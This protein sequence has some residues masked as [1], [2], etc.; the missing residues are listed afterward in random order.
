MKRTAYPSILLVSLILAACGGG[1]DAPS[2]A[3]MSAAAS[4]AEVT[5]TEATSDSAPALVLEAE[6]NASADTTPEALPDSDTATAPAP[7][8]TADTTADA[9]SSDTESDSVVAGVTTTSGTHLYVATTGSDSNP[10]TQTRPFKT[11]LRASQFAKPGTTVHVAPGTYVGG[12]TTKASGTATARIRYVSDRKWGAKIVP[13]STGSRTAWSERGS[14]VDI[15][16]FDI[17]GRSGQLWRN[18]INTF[19]SYNVIKNN[20]VHHIADKVACDNMGG[21]AINTTHYYYGVKD[22]VIG[23]V[24]HH[25][26]YKGCKFIQGIYIGTS[27]KVMN[28][29]VYQIGKNGIQMW[30][31]AHNVIVANNT[32]FKSDYGITVGGGDFYHITSNSNTHVSNN[33]VFDNVRGIEEVGIVGSN[34]T[35]T[36]NLVFRNSYRNIGLKSGKTHTGTITADPQFVNYVATGGG[37]YRLRSTSPAINKGKATY[38][39]SNDIVGTLR[40]QHAAD[41]IGAYEYK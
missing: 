30:H 16:G 9:S 21:S 33:I 27:G 32:I 19:G 10:G 14:Y 31:D 22:D 29:L 28:N 24:V 13:P 38:A 15:D 3:S 25:I 23:N 36:N 39:P 40:P 7:E 41:D 37:D 1:S 6:A 18:G 8:S 20:H 17:D 11:I 4:T 34:N 2:D 35:Y 12:F 26:G 5:D